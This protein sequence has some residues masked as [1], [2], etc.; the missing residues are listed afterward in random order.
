MKKLNKNFIIGFGLLS[1]FVIFTILVKFVDVEAIGPLNSKVGFAGLNEIFMINQSS[2]LWDVVSNI[3]MI[4]ALLCACMFVVIGVAEIVNR[5][6][7]KKVD[8]NIFVLAGLYIA[9]VVVYVFFEMVVINNRPI[10]EDGELAAS[11]PSSHVLISL[12]LL[13]STLIQLHRFYMKN[14]KFLFVVDII[15]VVICVVLVISRMLA[16]VHWITDIIGSILIS[17]AL[18]Y[19]YN[20]VLDK[21]MNNNTKD[22]TLE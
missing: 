20:G 4:I 8:K 7:I 21:I 11:F 18:I 13:F 5:K 3:T 17:G 6:S 19:I 1:L 16:G 15:V 9:I 14:N 12:T 10:L 22:K 2:S